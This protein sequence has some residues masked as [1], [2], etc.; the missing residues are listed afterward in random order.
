MKAYWLLIAILLIAVSTGCI[1]HH[2][3]GG[4][5]TFAERH[6]EFSF[7]CQTY[8]VTLNLSS[9]DLEE[10]QW[11]KDAIGAYNQTPQDRYFK[12]MIL[13]TKEDKAYE[14]VLND[15][16]P[17]RQTMG[18]DTYMEFISRFVQ[19]IPY[20]ANQ[21]FD[22]N[23]PIQVLLKDNGDCD[24]KSVLLAGLLAEEGYAVSLIHVHLS[25]VTDHMGV[26]I[27]SNGADFDK[28]GYMFIEATSPNWMGYT[29][30]PFYN[31]DYMPSMGSNGKTASSV[32]S[33]YVVQDVGLSYTNGMK[34]ETILKTIKSMSSY[35]DCWTRQVAI[36]DLIIGGG[37]VRVREEQDNLSVS[38]NNLRVEQSLLHEYENL[39]R[40]H[41]IDYAAY[42]LVYNRYKFDYD[43]YTPQYDKYK[44]DNDRLNMII[45][46]RNVIADEKSKWAILYNY[47]LYGDEDTNRQYGLVSAWIV[48]KG[49]AVK[50][51]C[52]DPW[53][54]FT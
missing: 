11:A 37:R 29:E 46:E 2:S 52:E 16:R 20:E 9:W 10:S 3:H 6:Y 28:T 25:G 34:A 13:G 51:I 35:D 22:P 45:E 21:S 30:H 33:V 49:T 26:G 12:A 32:P 27:R 7:N 43:I 19:T 31:T 48:T 38:E 39:Y 15:L 54:G 44:S 4:P 1:S 5:E 41:K 14:D 40:A 24:D 23:L 53:S 42:L 18:N 47:L 17:Y 50:G 8:E 36:G